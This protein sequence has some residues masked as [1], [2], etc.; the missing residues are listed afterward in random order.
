LNQD[1][2]LDKGLISQEQKKASLSKRLTVTGIKVSISAL[3]IY[4]ILRKTNISEILGVMK[5]AD[6]YLLVIAYSLLFVG[7]TVSTFRWKILL[8][9]Q[10]TDASFFYLF[11]SYLIGLFFSNLLPSTIGGDTVRIYDSW[12]IGRSKGKAVAVIFVDRLLGFFA[13]VLFALGALTV[14][15]NLTRDFPILYFWLI[16]GGVT[17]AFV[18]WLIFSQ[19]QKIPGFLMKMKIPFR[20]K[21][22][23]IMNR[24]LD[25]FKA[26]QGNRVAP[27]K[28]FGLSLLLQTNVVIHYYIISRALD[29]QVPIYDYFL[30]IPLAL[31]IM[32]IPI[33][34][35][36]IGLRENAFAFFLA[37]FAVSQ[38]DAVA[39]AWIAYSFVLFQGLLGGVVYA[40]RRK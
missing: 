8:K 1:I 4:W 35:N 13:L 28:A 3:L 19:K 36:A 21:I 23:S 7:N 25:A 24:I 22:Q 26:Y 14:S 27:L 38:A 15:R 5:S 34:I 6:M 2:S 30:I 11:K 12:R 37:S 18:I 10:G 39:L 9:A 40:F 17:M 16:P 29:L 32:M 33:S 31:F 20:K